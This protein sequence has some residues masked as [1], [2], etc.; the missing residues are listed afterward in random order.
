M[1]TKH[2]KREELVWALREKFKRERQEREK[3]RKGAA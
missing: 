3:A 1:K 2:E